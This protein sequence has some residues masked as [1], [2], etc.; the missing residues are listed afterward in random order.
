M[1]PNG[2]F[3]P[4]CGPYKEFK[5]SANI[6]HWE[7]AYNDSYSGKQ[8]QLVILDPQSQE[9]Q[10]P[11][12]EQCLSPLEHMLSNS[13]VSAP[14]PPQ[15]IL[16]LTLVADFS[17]HL[18]FTCAGVFLRTELPRKTQFANLH[19][20]LGNCRA[21]ARQEGKCIK[22]EELSGTSKGLVVP[23]PQAAFPSL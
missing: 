21:C 8:E 16:F 4:L 11:A 1:Q 5:L 22:Q 14:P 7:N 17:S 19:Y 23:V 6:Y 15:P 9:A 12:V 18:S 10:P 3:Q 13:P 20:L 2:S